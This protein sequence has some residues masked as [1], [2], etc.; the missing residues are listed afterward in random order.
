MF[1]ARIF[2]NSLEE[3]RRVLQRH[4]AVHKGD[5]EIVDSI[6]RSVDASQPLEKVFLRLRAVP[7]NIWDEK[8]YIVSI[9]N[10]ELKNVGK[11]SI[12][13][14]KK[15]FDTER[16][17]QEYISQNHL[18]NFVYDFVCHRFGEQYFIGEDGVDLEIIEGHPS[19]EF[20]SKTEDGLQKLLQLF[21]VSADQVIKGPSVVAIKKILQV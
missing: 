3:A 14:V 20:K 15:Q 12:I 13:P 11:Q 6:Y 17:A 18:D 5:Y 21:N 16:E 4:H 7:Q 2:L 19:I 8:P 9:K 10:T 1:D